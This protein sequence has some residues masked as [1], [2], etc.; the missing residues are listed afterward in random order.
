MV[1]R[2]SG[3]CGT[4]LGAVPSVCH[5]GKNRSSAK[6]HPENFLSPYLGAQML[7]K[8]AQNFRHPFFRN[9]SR[10]V[11]LGPGYEAHGGVPEAGPD[12]ALARAARGL[13][14]R[15]GTPTGPARA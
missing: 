3:S 7:V 12:C 1:C 14:P 11:R 13:D 4:T 9:R 15:Q 2:A 8:V 5:W 10:K 6:R